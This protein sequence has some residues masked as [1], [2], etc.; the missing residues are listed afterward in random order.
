MDVL[1]VVDRQTKCWDIWLSAAKA[2]VSILFIRSF[3]FPIFSL[4]KIRWVIVQCSSDYFHFQ[5]FLQKSDAKTALSN[6]SSDHHFHSQLCFF[7]KI[8][9]GFACSSD[10]FHF[11][12]Q[13]GFCLRQQ[14]SQPALLWHGR[15]TVFH[16]KRI[17]EKDIFQL[18]KISEKYSAHL[19]FILRDFP[20]MKNFWATLSSSLFHLERFSE[21]K[22]RGNIFISTDFSN[23][24][25]ISL[26]FRSISSPLLL[27]RTKFISNRKLGS[28]KK[29]KMLPRKFFFIGSLKLNPFKQLHF[30]IS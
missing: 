26:S 3:S 28:V 8:R 10:H 13:V 6:C 5:F 7:P 25:L 20:T 14:L 19:C 4:Q 9:W 29:V 11:K 18:W 17:S 15:E 12:N 22:I 1:K 2:A 27:S 23:I 24:E 16:F 21:K 30:F